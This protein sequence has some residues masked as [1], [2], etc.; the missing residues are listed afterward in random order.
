LRQ[1]ILWKTVTKTDIC[2][3]WRPETEISIILNNENEITGLVSGVEYS[4]SCDP[5]SQVPY[6]GKNTRRPV[7]EWL[8]FSFLGDR[9][10]HFSSGH[11]FG[12][13][14]RALLL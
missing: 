5:G 3:E 10:E 4:I 7:K 13:T 9:V 12:N 6:L 2:D 1:F 8:Y 14:Y 11:P